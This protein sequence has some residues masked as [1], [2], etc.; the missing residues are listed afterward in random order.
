MI[1]NLWSYVKSSCKIK[2]KGKI[3]GRC[4]AQWW[5]QAL[6]SHCLSGYLGSSACSPPNYN[7]L[8]T[9]TPGEVGGWR[10]SRWWFKQWGSLALTWES[11]IKTPGPEYWGSEPMNQADGWY[12]SFII[13]LYLSLS[14]YFSLSVSL[15]FFSLSIYISMKISTVRTVSLFVEKK[16]WHQ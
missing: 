10:G 14:L 1:W 8:L 6:I 13:I 11:Q 5:T 3:R 4:L 15:S 7:F 2:I 12:A 9:H 16:N